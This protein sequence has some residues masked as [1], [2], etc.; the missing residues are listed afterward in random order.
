MLPA[1]ATQELCDRNGKDGEMGNQKRVL[2]LAWIAAPVWK[3]GCSI[4]RRARLSGK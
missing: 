4:D 3:T 2:G 1:P